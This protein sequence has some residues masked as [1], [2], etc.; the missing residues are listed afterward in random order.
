MRLF[1]P[2][3]GAKISGALFVLIVLSLIITGIAFHQ[4][5][6]IEKIVSTDVMEKSDARHLSNS[7]FLKCEY[8]FNL[9]K[10]YLPSKKESRQIELSIIISDETRT[11][12]EYMRQV[13]KRRL[14]GEEKKVFDRIEELFVLYQDNLRHLLKDSQWRGEDR[15]REKA[16]N[17]FRDLHL[18]FTTLL[19]QFDRIETDLMYSSWDESKERINVIKKSV[20]LFSII[21]CVMGLLL[22]FFLTR[23]VTHPISTLVTVLEKYSK[24]DFNVRSRIRTEDEIGFFAD[25]FN[26]MLDQLQSVNQ[27]L[28]NIIDFLPDATFVIDRKGTVIAWNRAMEEMTG[29][30]K[31]DIVGQA[32]FAY[33]IPFYGKRRPI[34][35]D[36]VL[37]PDEKTEKKYTGLLRRGPYVYAES[38][39][40]MNMNRRQ[41][42]LWGVAAP[43]YD[44]RGNITGAIE[45]LRD[46][47]TRKEAET[48]LRESEERYRTILNSIEDGYYEVDLYGNFTFFNPSMCRILGYSAEELRGMNNRQYMS[49]QNAKIAYRAFNEV[50]IKGNLP[51]PFEAEIIKK[52]GTIIHTE[53]TFS[54]IKNDEGKATSFRGILRDISDRKRAEELY[55]ALAMHAQSAVSIVQDG[56]F[57][58]VNPYVCSYSGFEEAE[59][60]GRESLA[61]IHPDD[62]ISAKREGVRM[63][64]GERSTPYEFRLVRKDGNIRWHIQTVTS[65]FFEGRKAALLNTMDV[66]EKKTAED[67]IRKLNEELEK[68]VLER[69]AELEA[70]NK[71]LESFSYSISH[72]LRTPL[73]AIDGFSR[74]LIDEQRELSSSDM[75]RYLNMV[76][77]NAQQMSRLIDDILN[78]SRMG[79]Q[80]L[81][82]VKVFPNDIVGQALE[83][84]K[85]SYE[86]RTVDLA[87][88]DMAACEADP[89]LLKVVYVNL[90][91]NALKFTKN[92]EVA[93]ID[94]GSMKDGEKDVYYIGDNG[95]GFDMKYAEKIFGVFQRL[96]RAEDFEGTGVGMSIVQRIIHRHGGSIRVESEIG[97][98]T[99]FYFTL[100]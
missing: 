46:V 48:A 41:V 49:S 7:I 64:K 22:G 25:K 15:R 60:M 65:I 55:R 91:S 36:L 1:P 13:K 86:G 54:L 45:S 11:I 8:V 73:R 92:R 77:N 10:E 34:L 94:I 14:T 79:R 95:V 44:G 21:A 6:S 20:L 99:K 19:L 70:A 74:I 57:R 12:I 28:M 89:A 82:K 76:R 81:K 24:G 80:S 78:F 39:S 26:L 43:L 38:P 31:E 75:Q 62:R 5:V 40:I 84:L 98:G 87:V 23:S 58:F 42:Y 56:R 33:A 47:T 53:T 85:G 3:I 27:Q 83:E 35:I 50:F 9:V 52:D 16:F 88:S 32:D 66:T 17:E 67:E 93:R 30:S 59:L 71:E 61:I 29:V 96:H 100:S 18:Q 90:L 97:K 37:T 69:T 63:L 68:R 4:F 72:D 51:K 2:S